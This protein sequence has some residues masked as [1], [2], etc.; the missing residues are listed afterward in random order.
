M[1]CG[2]W[3]DAFRRMV[4]C[5]SAYG[6][7]PFGSGSV[8]FRLGSICC[9][10]G[11]RRVIFGRV[12][13]V[14]GNMRQGMF[15]VS[16]FCVISVLIG[17]REHRTK[18]LG[19]ASKISWWARNTQGKIS[20]QSMVLPRKDQGS[21]FVGGGG[22]RGIGWQPSVGRVRIQLWTPSSK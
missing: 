6:W 17:A 5:L 1:P 19:A 21:T 20:A 16:H 22:C 15:G 9:H 12:M 7:M 14:M 8:A 11:F 13:F 18:K 2:V 10:V 3:L 4:G